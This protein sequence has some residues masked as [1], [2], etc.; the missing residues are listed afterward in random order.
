[1]VERYIFKDLLEIIEEFPVVGIVGP[2]QVGKTTLAKL[3][4]KQI[5]KET[6]FLDL[7]NPRDASKL[8][9]PLL[10]FENN[11]TKCIII[12]EVQINKE[13]FPIIRTVV[14]QQREPGRFILLGSASPE[15]IRDSSESLA[16]RIY[17]K[18]LTP[19]HFKEINEIVTYQKHW[20]YGGYPEALL[21]ESPTKSKRWRRSFIQTYIERDLPMLGLSSKTSD[22][23]R[24]FRMISHIHGQQLNYNTLSKSLGLSS[25]TI[26]KQ[27]DFLEHAYII[28]LLEPYYFNTS[29]RLVKSPKIY[30]RDTGLLHSLLEIDDNEYLFGHPIIGNSWEG[31]VIEQ[32]AAVLPEDYSLNYYR[33]QQGAELDLVVCKNLRPILGIEIK[34]SSNPKFS[35]G[36]EISLQDLG[37]DKGYIVVPETEGY[38]LKKNVE[39]VSLNLLINLIYKL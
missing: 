29:K 24:L 5:K 32:V 28:R 33:T 10:F 30:I 7:E 26:K 36:N 20:L 22:I 39:V 6:I 18:E 19:F 14:D 17:Y 35:V 12:D 1:M 27:V 21:T 31:Y 9:D 38:F 11:Q 8:T 3:L 16:G 25:P 13:L 2:R 37:L 15:L 4:S 23:H 34:L